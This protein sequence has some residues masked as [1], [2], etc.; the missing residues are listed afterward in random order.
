MNNC[1]HRFLAYWFI[2]FGFI[3]PLAGLFAQSPEISRPEAI[4]FHVAQSIKKDNLYRHIQ[5]L[6]SD[7]LEGREF[8]TF[9]INRAADYIVSRLKKAGIKPMGDRG[10]YYQPVT[11]Q[12]WSWEKLSLK[13]NDQELIPGIDF[14]AKIFDNQQA[15]KLSGTQFMFMGYGI[16]T[17][18]YNDYQYA[19]GWDELMLIL[20]GEPIVDGK[21]LLTESEKLSIWSQDLKKKIEQA[22][23]KNAK[24]ILLLRDSIYFP[25]KSGNIFD[26]IEYSM[27][28]IE[29]YELPVI[30]INIA[31]LPKIF[32][33]QQLETI[34]QYIANV[35]EGKIASNYVPINYNIE[36]QSN[37][38]PV[39]G[40]NIVAVIEGSDPALKYKYIALSAHY[41]HLGIRNGQ[42]YNGADDNASGTA[43]LIEVATALQSLKNQKGG[44]KRSVMILFFTGEEKG[45]LGSKFF[46][47]NP[48]IPLRMIRS[49]I[50]IDMIGRADEDHLDQA[51][52]VYVIGS[53]KINILLDEAISEANKYSVNYNLDYRYNDENH[54]SRLYYRSDHYNF[55]RLG[56]PSVFFFG[57]FHADYHQPGDDI[58]KINLQK[59]Q[60]I[61]RLVY[62]TLINLANYDG[63]IRTNYK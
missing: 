53:D 40:R 5:I 46:V 62:F 49:N 18:Q 47:K 59:V 52:Y 11:V 2:I 43:A 1:T 28:S 63:T 15:V 23:M 50:N 57:G 27:D 58:E 10:T 30:S 25:K 48:S 19:Q 35:K 39:F 22:K 13:M 45:L 55:A 33:G 34:H 56:I 7:S 6:A 51:S 44:L 60:D 41:Y 8:G 26:R 12:G 29:R 16:K 37:F 54:P 20:D 31:A 32:K 3:F 61:S 17:D 38:K 21:S 4:D 36:L 14:N 9:G 42:V 24:G